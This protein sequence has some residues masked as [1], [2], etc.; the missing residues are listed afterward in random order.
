MSNKQTRKMSVESMAVA[1]GSS[2]TSGRGTAPVDVDDALLAY[3]EEI[4]EDDIFM[5]AGRDGAEKTLHSMAKRE[6]A[7][8]L[9]AAPMITLVEG[10]PDNVSWVLGGLKDGKDQLVFADGKFKWNGHASALFTGAEE[11]WFIRL[12]ER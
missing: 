6:K 4:G 1:S 7:E 11:G 8:G 10:K 5:V 9:V 3:S 2:G 12:G